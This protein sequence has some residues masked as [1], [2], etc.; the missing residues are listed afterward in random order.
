MAQQSGNDEPLGIKDLLL[1]E[2]GVESGKAL[3]QNTRIQRAAALAAFLQSRANELLTSVEKEQQEEFDKLIRNPADRA[4]LVQ[5]TDQ[6][7][8]SNSLHRSADQLVHILDVQGIPGFFSP[9][10][11]VM[12]QNFKLILLTQ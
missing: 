4:T 10:D 2:F 12:L 6:V 9:F 1:S 3:D 11:K 7:F 5:M 8:R